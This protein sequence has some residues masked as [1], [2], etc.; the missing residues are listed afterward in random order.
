MKRI[1]ITVLLV[2]L[3]IPQAGALAAYTIPEDALAAPMPVYDNYGA[4]PLDEAYRL[5][6]VI[7]RARDSGLLGED[8]VV[9]FNA[10]DGDAAI[11]A[12]LGKTEEH[13][14]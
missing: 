2:C 14:P 5:D 9:A 11:L 12:C 8:E 7:Q 1:L 13:R 6:D 3:L 4:C 10:E